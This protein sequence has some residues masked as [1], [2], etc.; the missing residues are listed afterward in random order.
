MERSRPVFSD[1]GTVCGGTIALVMSPFVGGVR[2]L[3][4]ARSTISRSRVTLAMTAAV[5]TVA[6]C[7]SPLTLVVMSAGIGTSGASNVLSALVM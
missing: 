2:G 1:G 3:L 7:W 6:Q 5:A 4:C